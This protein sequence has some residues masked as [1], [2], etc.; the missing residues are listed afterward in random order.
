MAVIPNLGPHPGSSRYAGSTAL[1]A[2]YLTQL[3]EERRVSVAT[4]R[5][6]RAALAAIHKAH[7]HEDPTDHEGVRQVMKGAWQAARISRQ[8]F[9]G[10]VDIQGQDSGAVVQR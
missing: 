5:L 1:V 8:S 10:S 4:V 3:A 7:S 9:L 6:H 2:A